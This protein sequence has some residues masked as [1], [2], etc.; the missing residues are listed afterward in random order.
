M[1]EERRLLSVSYL[2]NGVIRLGVDSGLG[3]AITYLSYSPSYNHT[4]A[5]PN[6]INCADTGR[7]I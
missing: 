6:V 5:E 2:D 1:L 4:P 7:E 3:G